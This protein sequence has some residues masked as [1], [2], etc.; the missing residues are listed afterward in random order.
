[1]MVKQKNPSKGQKQ[2]PEITNRK[3]SILNLITSNPKISRAKMSIQ[4]GLTDKQVRTTLNQLVE[5]G[6]I[7]HEGPDHGG[8]W[9][10]L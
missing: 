5:E 1:M 4:L 10:I 6:N 2:G 7:K 9:I 3:T 8:Q